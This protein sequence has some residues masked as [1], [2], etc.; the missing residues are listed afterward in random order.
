MLAREPG[1]TEAD[2][3]TSG[4]SLCLTGPDP[5]RHCVRQRTENGGHM[6]HARSP[7]HQEQCT[8][9]K[10][11]RG[12]KEVKKPKQPERAPST[13]AALG[14]LQPLTAPAVLPHKPKKR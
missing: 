2:K 4:C 11:Q 5:L 14:G 10:G 9:S 1:D 7:H 6:G 12:N 8:M 13:P 3:R